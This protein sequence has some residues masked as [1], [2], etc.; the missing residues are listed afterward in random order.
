MKNALILHGTGANSHSN[1][2][3]WLA[4]K[5][6]EKGYE[7]YIPQLPHTDSPDLK[8]NRRFI[9]A[10]EFEFSPETIIVGHSS[11][12][13]LAL[14]LLEMLPVGSRIDTV[15]AVGAYQPAD[16]IDKIRTNMVQNKAR[17]LIFVHGDNDPIAPLEGVKDLARQTAGKL[18]IVPGAQH[19][20]AQ[21]SPEHTQLPILVD[22][23]G[24]SKG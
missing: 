19:F 15:V 8:L 23:L 1:W 18:V 5:L 7:V 10:G 3:D 17:R 2:F 22:I 14:K 9:F 13:V 20:S 16:F 21:Q 12:A 6:S 24:L 4:S 11:G